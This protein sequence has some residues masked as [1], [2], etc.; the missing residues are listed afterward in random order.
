MRLETTASFTIDS[1]SK[2]RLPEQLALSALCNE[3]NRFFQKYCMYSTTRS[4]NSGLSLQKC[5]MPKLHHT[6]HLW[7]PTVIQKENRFLKKWTHFMLNGE[8]NSDK[9][10]AG[11]VFGQSNP[12]EWFSCAEMLTCIAAHWLVFGSYFSTTSTGPCW[13]PNP[14]KAY[15]TSACPSLG[16]VRLLCISCRHSGLKWYRL[17][18]ST[19]SRQSRLFLM[20]ICM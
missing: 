14:P 19:R 2:G 11:Y 15:M 13:L 12:R 9:I 16:L 6:K 8:K 20:R 18:S 4:Y 5:K 7:P 1:L 10:F 3:N 17:A